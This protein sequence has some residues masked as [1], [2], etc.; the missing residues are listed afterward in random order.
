MKEN[1]KSRETESHLAGLYY[2]AEPPHGG[3]Y[4]CG[5]EDEFARILNACDGKGN[6]SDVPLT[7]TFGRNRKFSG[8]VLDMLYQT[9]G[10]N[11]AFHIPFE[12]YLSLGRPE[13]IRSQIVFSSAKK[14]KS[15]YIPKTI[16][17]RVDA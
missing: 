13:V 3:G 1:V 16:K 11:Q 8:R 10:H 6:F 17:K 2:T 7:S 12:D 14:I 9:I 4:V 15:K 5:Q